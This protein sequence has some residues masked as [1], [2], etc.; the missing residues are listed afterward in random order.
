MI[1]R[2]LSRRQERLESHLAPVSDP[3]VIEVQLISSVDRSV[4]DRIRFTI[5]PAA[6]NQKGDAKA[7][8][9]R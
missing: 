5:G 2:N 1:N 7:M 9:S 6:G 4:V 3:L 8:T